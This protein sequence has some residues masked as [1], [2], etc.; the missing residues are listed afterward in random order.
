MYQPAGGCSRI[1]IGNRIII[2]AD[3]DMPP[4]QVVSR[5]IVD[6]IVDEV[7]DNLP[8]EDDVPVGSE[9]AVLAHRACRSR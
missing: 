3:V 6:A 7:K 4:T 8:I 2:A 5:A 9:T 1:K